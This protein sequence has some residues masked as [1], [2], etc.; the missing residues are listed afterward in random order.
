MS[1]IYRPDHPQANEN[2]MIDRSLDYAER[3]RGP[4]IIS[5]TMEALI[6]PITGKRMDSKSAFRAVT[7]AHGCEEVGNEVQ[8]DTRSFDYTSGADVAEAIRQL[9][10]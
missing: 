6:H 8:R 1:L 5:D 2:G 10:G 7:R 9:G 3:G 4:Q